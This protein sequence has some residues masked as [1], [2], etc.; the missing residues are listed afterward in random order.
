MSEEIKNQ[1]DELYEKIDNEEY[2]IDNL[3]NEISRR[4]GNI[5]SYRNEIEDLEILLKEDEEN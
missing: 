2:E 5:H 1:I 4:N 3:R